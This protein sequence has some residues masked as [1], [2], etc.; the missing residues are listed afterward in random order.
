MREKKTTRRGLNFRA[1]EV[2]ELRQGVGV[3]QESE[4]ADGGNSAR[5]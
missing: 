4:G 1:L 2:I 3:E 5:A